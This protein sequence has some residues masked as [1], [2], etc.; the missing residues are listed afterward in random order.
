[1]KKLF[2][3]TLALVFVIGV[4]IFTSI[5]VFAVNYK[6][7]VAVLGNMQKGKTQVIRRIVGLPFEEI[8]ERSSWAKGVYGVQKT[9]Y[10]DGDLFECNYY[11]APGY[12]KCTNA[13]VD[14]QIESDAIKIANIA[15][16]VVD[17]QQKVNEI[18][19]GFTSS[20]DEALT[21]H[22]T[23]VRKINS[24]CK[25]IVVINKID[26]IKDVEKL[27][28]YKSMLQGARML[29]RNLETDGIFTSAKD[30][31]G[32]QDLEEMIINLFKSDK[33]N[34][35]TFD[36]S[37]V[38]CKFDNVK[39]RKDMCVKGNFGDF[40]C[41]EGCLRQAEAK[42]CSYSKC[43]DKRSFLEVRNEGFVS[44]TTR[45]MYCSKEHRQLAEVRKPCANSI[46]CSNKGKRYLV[47]EGFVSSHTDRL[48]C[49][50]SCYVSSEGQCCDGKDCTRRF[51]VKDEGTFITSSKSGKR[52]CSDECRRNAEDRCVIM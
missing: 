37:F 35:S 29:H 26:E 2:R 44:V 9:Y 40:Y 11:D 4:Y 22:A 27:E 34:F 36:G 10:I 30:G 21:R 16:I 50:K 15:L 25:V 51:V 43:T 48:Y 14:E 12:L 17:P 8:S 42:P 39:Q 20:I 5:N 38:H 45:K 49:S 47:D 52:Y 32:I 3:S 13:T 18:M 19:T 41:S 6:V 1:M 24:K 31:T 28:E 46:N 23:N 33:N 7:N